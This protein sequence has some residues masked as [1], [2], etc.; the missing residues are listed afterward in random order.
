MSSTDPSVRRILPQES[1]NA[2]AMGMNS[3][4]FAPQQFPQRE[5]QKSEMTRPNHIPD[6]LVES[7]TNT[8]IIDYVFVDEHNR[9][10]RLKGNPQSWLAV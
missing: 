7:Q 9:H 6:D 8:P 2:Q 1:Q 4:T 3:Y 10:K 5:T